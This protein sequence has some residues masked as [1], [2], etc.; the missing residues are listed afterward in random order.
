MKNNKPLGGLK[1]QPGEGNQLNP[2]F[3]PLPGQWAQDQ[4]E[5]RTSQM[6]AGSRSSAGNKQP[7]TELA[8]ELRKEAARHAYWEEWQGVKAAKPSYADPRSALDVV[9]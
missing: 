8:K 9:Y 1:P 5:G 3:H 2:K 6:T 7:T 4:I